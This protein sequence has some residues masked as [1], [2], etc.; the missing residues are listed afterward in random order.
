MSKWAPARLQI[1]RKS[2]KTG[3]AQQQLAR[4][5]MAMDLMGVHR[6]D[7]SVLVIP[8]DSAWL[9]VIKG[10]FIGISPHPK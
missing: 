8:D 4:I 6:R 9:E 1:D 5:L 10:D 2:R 7:T 3:L